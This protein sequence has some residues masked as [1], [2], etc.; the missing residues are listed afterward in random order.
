[1]RLE[2]MARGQQDIHSRAPVEMRTTGARFADRLDSW[3]GIDYQKRYL[4][5][6]A[7]PACASAG[8][9]R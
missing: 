9:T 7:I 4:L 2:A 5:G 6:G 1:M 3:E 8:I